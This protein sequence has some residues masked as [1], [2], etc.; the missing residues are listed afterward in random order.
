MNDLP[1]RTFVTDGQLVPYAHDVHVLVDE[2]RQ[3]KVGF[4][5]GGTVHSQTRNE[6]GHQNHTYLLFLLD[7]DDLLR[8]SR[9]TEGGVG[10]TG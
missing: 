1:A 8:K 6:N 7:T 4:Q 5:R 9:E 3:I 10:L 2:I